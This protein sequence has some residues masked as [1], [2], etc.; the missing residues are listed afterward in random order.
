MA[1]ILAPVS[2]CFEPKYYHFW[3]YNERKTDLYKTHTMPMLFLVSSLTI[4]K[5]TMFVKPK[6]GECDSHK[7]ETLKL[8]CYHGNITVCYCVSFLRYITGVKFQ[9]QYQRY[10]W[11][12]TKFILS[13]FLLFLIF[14]MIC[15]HTVV[16]YDVITYMMSS[17]VSFSR[18]KILQKRTHHSS[19]F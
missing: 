18:E 1:T 8:N 12:G 9:T 6:K 7:T 3:L 10:T 14:L 4:K 5:W 17:L 11:Y 2:F 19:S 15:C 16:T 13:L